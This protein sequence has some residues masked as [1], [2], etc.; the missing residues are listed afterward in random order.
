MTWSLIEESKLPQ[1][2]KFFPATKNHSYLNST[3]CITTD[4]SSLLGA[5]LNRDMLSDSVYK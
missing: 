5:Y 1:E 2:N 3:N 4:E